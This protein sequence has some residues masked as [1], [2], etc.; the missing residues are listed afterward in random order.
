MTDGDTDGRTEA[1]EPADGVGPTGTEGLGE[2]D[3]PG[4]GREGVA[5]ALPD[6]NGALNGAFSGQYG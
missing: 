4:V 2:P 5:E 6:G 3:K 1:P